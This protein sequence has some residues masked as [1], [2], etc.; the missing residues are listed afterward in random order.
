[1]IVADA[2]RLSLDKPMA[3]HLIALAVQYL[4]PPAVLAMSVHNFSNS[5]ILD[6]CL[7]GQATVPLV[8]E[9]F[10]DDVGVEV[11]HL[12]GDCRGCY[13]AASYR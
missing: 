5:L 3:C 4:A 6:D 9:G 11:V 1:M 8:A 12:L 10:A 13:D 2:L 7:V